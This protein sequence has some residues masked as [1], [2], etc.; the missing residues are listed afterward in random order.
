MIGSSAKALVAR[1]DCER[2]IAEIYGLAGPLDLTDACG[3]LHVAAVGHDP[4]GTLHAIAIEPRSPRSATDLFLLNLA[5]ARADAIV[6]TGKILR[7]E[8]RTTHAIGGTADEAAA[9]TAWRR[10]RLGKPSAPLS[11]VLTSGR[12]LDWRHPLFHQGTPVAVVTDAAA[13]RA[14]RAGAIPS[15]IEVVERPSPSL[16]DAIEVLRGERGCACVS[17]EAGPSTTADLYDPPP[18]IDE[19]MLSLYEERDLPESLRAGRFVDET[20]LREIF[21]R[22][23]AGAPRREES[24]RWSF[25]RY[26]RR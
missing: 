14:L 10:E 6:T 3:V 2:R 26:L 24:G 23:E 16:R 25:R 17:I 22:R 19:L 21:A 1:I 9:L 11:V 7:E 15:G 4:S 18:A 13:A 5:R 20:R 8:P 12:N